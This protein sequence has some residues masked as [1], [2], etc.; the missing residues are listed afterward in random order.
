MTRFFLALLVSLVALMAAPTGMARQDDERLKD[1][2]TRLQATQNVQEARA[3]EALIWSIWFESGNETV[4]RLLERGNEAMNRGQMIDALAQFNSVIE[5]DPK[6]AEGWNRR[7]T[8]LYLMGDLP[9]SLRDID[10]TLELEPRHFGALSG[11]GLIRT[12]L[13]QVE[14]AIA[15]FER[16]MAINP[17]LV[18][19]KENLRELRRRIGRDI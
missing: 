7:A 15:A 4:N 13:D 16:A 10:R 17:H 14:A 19:G 11:L 2:F 1:L 8:L 12:N 3:I 18:G 5:I 6:L 9:S